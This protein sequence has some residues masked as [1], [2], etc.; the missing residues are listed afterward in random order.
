VVPL[1]HAGDR[2]DEQPVEARQVGSGRG[3]KLHDRDDR[4]E[5][6]D[7]H[8]AERGDEPHRRERNQ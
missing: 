7:D 4:S 1:E 6:L 5:Q 3:A 8:K 2:L